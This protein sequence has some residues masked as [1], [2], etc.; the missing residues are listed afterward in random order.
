MQQLA[1]VAGIGMVNFIASMVF[2][3]G[4]ASQLQFGPSST[5]LLYVQDY[6]RPQANSTYIFDANSGSC[7]SAIRFKY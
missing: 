7:S 1:L 6:R 3:T 5:C 2:T 4:I